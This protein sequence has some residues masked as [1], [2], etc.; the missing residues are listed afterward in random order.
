MVGRRTDTLGRAK[1]GSTAG[2]TRLYSSGLSCSTPTKCLSIESRQGL[3][4]E[5]V[6]M[7]LNRIKIQRGIPTMLYCDNGSELKLKTIFEDE[8]VIVPPVRDSSCCSGRQHKEVKKS[9]VPDTFQLGA[10][11]ALFDF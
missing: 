10:I 6:V 1:H 3:K 9:R 4:G 11:S 8:W 2:L 7:T 5:D